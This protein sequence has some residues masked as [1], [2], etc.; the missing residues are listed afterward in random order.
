MRPIPTSVS[1]ETELADVFERFEEPTTLVPVVAD[2]RLI[3][4]LDLQ[5]V[6]RYA[7]LH[8]ELQIP[9]TSTA[10]PATV[11]GCGRATAG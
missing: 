3:G 6:L 8:E 9:P 4:V 11:E 5:Q 1:P 7:Q 10:R 2:E